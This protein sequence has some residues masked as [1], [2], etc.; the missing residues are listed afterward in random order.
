M[1]G[2]VE[3][4]YRSALEVLHEAAAVD[5]P[6][7]FPQPVLGALRRLV[8][9]DVVTYHERIAGQPRLVFTSEPRGPV[10]LE[11]RAAVRRFAFEIDSA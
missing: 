11:I 1:R 8:P 7:P 10:S 2:L 6:I 3:S 9:C 5:G 4:D